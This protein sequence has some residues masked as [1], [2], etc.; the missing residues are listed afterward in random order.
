MI[1]HEYKLPYISPMFHTGII[2]LSMNKLPHVS[3]LH[4]KTI[5]VSMSS[6]YVKVSRDYIDES[7]LPHISPVFHTDIRMLS[8]NIS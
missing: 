5:I 3:S 7:K 2:M 1:V 4:D 8:M 6:C